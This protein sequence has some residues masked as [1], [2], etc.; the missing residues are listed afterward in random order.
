MINGMFKDHFDDATF[1]DLTIRLSD[2]TL[3]VHR[4]VLCRQSQYFST[5][6]TG[7]FKVCR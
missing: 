2:R 5:L 7:P 6:L 3:K 4:V 1:S